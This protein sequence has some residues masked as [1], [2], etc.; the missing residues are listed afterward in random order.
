[1]STV[2]N[3]LII[4]LGAVGY[5]MADSFAAQLRQRHTGARFPA[6]QFLPLLEEEG[7]SA[8]NHSLPAL[9]IKVNAGHKHIRPIAKHLFPSR[10]WATTASEFSQQLAQAPRPRGQIALHHYIY[11]ITE[12]IRSARRIIFS[13]ATLDQLSQQS[14]SVAN[15]KRLNV[16]LLVSLADP[17]MS[18]LLPDLPYIIDH[19]LSEAT[20]EDT[21]IDINLILAL[22]GF[23]GD[24]SVG[25]TRRVNAHQKMALEA[26][27]N[28]S[29]AAC[30]REVDYF[31]AEDH[32]YDRQ[33]ASFLRIKSNHNPLG[34]G[35]IYLLEPTNEAEKTL[36]DVTALANMSGEWLYHATMTGLRETVEAPQL[37][38]RGRRYSSFGHSSLRV[39]LGQWIE[40]VAIK[41][42]IELLGD[43]LRGGKRGDS[44]ETSDIAAI[45]TQ[46]HIDEASL[47]NALTERTSYRDIRL[48]A[49]QFRNIPLA[50]GAQFIKRVQKRYSD[51]LGQQLPE[52]RADILY[53]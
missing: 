22:P 33:F 23:Q 40:R 36:D 2:S 15:P 51:T 18:G 10:Q 48:Q 31:L 7:H 5:K 47:R 17:F 29:A 13:S 6:I 27:T 26:E 24:V 20:P 1:M 19:I 12:R 52:T 44:A 30:L 21:F 34:G 14:M 49:L 28:A 9:G 35:R 53:R 16:Y 32:H 41:K 8:E 50:N 4:S 39:P 25:Q 37:L 3:T 43:M 46:L 11:D 42:E 38:A 45:R